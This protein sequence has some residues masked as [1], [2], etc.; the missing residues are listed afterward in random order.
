MTADAVVA[1]VAA[2]D[3]PLRLTLRRSTQSMFTRLAR[4]SA[5]NRVHP[6]RQRAP[7]WLLSITDR[8]DGPAV[9]LTQDFLAQTLDVRRSSVNQVA[10][11]FAG[12]GRPSDRSAQPVGGAGTTGG[13]VGAGVSAGVGAGVGVGAAAA[14]SGPHTTRLPTL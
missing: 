8:V 10:G 4:T 2:V 13:V 11:T 6:V 12:P 1:A 14:G 7:R 9:D 5:C 3:G